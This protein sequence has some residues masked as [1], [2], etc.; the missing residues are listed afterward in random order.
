MRG[1]P[2]DGTGATSP[3][4]APEADV[5]ALVA[6]GRFT[7]PREA[8]A[9]LDDALP[10]LES[11]G[12]GRA[13]LLALFGRALLARVAARPA[14]D[15]VEACDLL[16][17]AA[18]ERRAPVWAACAAALRARAK[19]D[20]GDVGSAVND[21]ARVDLER[22]GPALAERPGLLLLDTLAGAFAR[23]R[24]DEQ[25][26]DARARF[27]ALIAAACPLDR[28]VHWS[29]WSVQLAARALDPVASGRGEPDHRLLERALEVSAR[30]G[31]LGPRVVPEQ[32]HRSVQAVGALAAAYR[33][34]PSEA[35]R[36]LG[37]DAFGEARDLPPLERQIAGLAAIRAHALVGSV[38]TAR[39]LDDGAAP[40]PAGLPHLVLEACRARERLWLESHAGGPVVPALSR[41]DDVLAR[42]AWLGMD[43]VAQTARQVLEHQALR[44]ES[45]TDPLT[46]VGNRRALDEEMRHMLRFTPMPLALVLIDIDDFKQINDAFTHVVGDEV[47]RRVA[48]SLG[49]ELRMG[50]HLARYG[51]DE[52]IALL[53]RT[54]DAE[55]RHVAERMRDAVA[56]TAWSDVAG[57]LQVRVTTGAA[58]LWSLT[59]RRPDRDAE[60]LFR[61][62]DEALLDAKHARATQT[63]A[64]GWP[65]G[66]RRRRIAP[67]ATEESEPV[68]QGPITAPVTA[69]VGTHALRNAHHG[70]PAHS[71]QADDVDD[72]PVPTHDEQE[73]EPRD[74][75]PP[76]PQTRRRR[77]TVIDLSGAATSRTPFG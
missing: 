65:V 30:V 36:L 75:M 64:A 10:A 70:H 11:G 39:S 71:L 2:D 41:L 34:R 44:A 74:G 69:P 31:D 33:G 18:L 73:P 8:L 32:V 25:A 20:A 48:G 1:W 23:L 9:R 49:R 22:L 57:G 6:W 63:P 13:V 52:F 66:G 29:G 45:R 55:A 50:D 14:A 43:L 12:D 77:A 53:P 54:G 58:A 42:M 27:E 28:A 17:R 37:Q 67:A 40:A 16:E 68:P 76:M 46:G 60:N 56:R 19:L 21:L 26:E 62:A 72:V 5:E 61:R 35:L 24:L 47:L 15:V 38:A 4:S 59:G 3:A 51:G 7:D